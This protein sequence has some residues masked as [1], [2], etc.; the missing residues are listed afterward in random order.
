MSIQSRWDKKSVI[1][2]IKNYSG[3]LSA[4]QIQLFYPRLYGAAFR[5]FGG[6]RKAIE[7]SGL[8]YLQITKKRRGRW[9]RKLVT[10]QIRQLRHKNSGYV[11]GANA[12]LYNAALRVF[13]SWKNAV[14]ASGIDYKGVKKRQNR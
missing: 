9:T 1:F 2:E 3:D 8:D 6:W 12:A 14:E 11:R 10:K 13:G 5:I 7:A 4:R